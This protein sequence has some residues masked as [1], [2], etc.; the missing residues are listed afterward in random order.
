VSR[1]NCPFQIYFQLLLWT[2]FYFQTVY[3]SSSR[4]F[5]LF[6]NPSKPD[7]FQKWFMSDLDGLSKSCLSQHI[8]KNSI[9][10]F[11][12]VVCIKCKWQRFNST[13]CHQTF[14]YYW[15]TN[16]RNFERPKSS[17]SF[18]K[19]RLPNY[20]VG[21]IN[22]KRRHSALLTDIQFSFMCN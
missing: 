3:F 7:Q 1:I 18:H 16:D 22:Y 6:S 9:N 13:T 12:Y 5:H 19:I 2:S 8:D 14:N 21:I 20:V 17:R 15:M 11:W 10:I 4:T